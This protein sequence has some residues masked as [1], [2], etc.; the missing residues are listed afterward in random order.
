MT[1]MEVGEAGGLGGTLSDERRERRDVSLSSTLG[2]FLGRVGI[3]EPDRNGLKEPETGTLVTLEARE[4]R[5]ES[6]TA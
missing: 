5:L 1:A 4:E 6:A 3:K 2:R